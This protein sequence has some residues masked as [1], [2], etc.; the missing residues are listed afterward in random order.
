MDIHGFKEEDITIL[1]DDGSHQNPTYDNILAAFGQLVTQTKAGDC[2][3]LHYSGK[4]R[5]GCFCD[6]CLWHAQLTINLLEICSTGHGGRVKDEDGDEEDGYDET[7]IPVD[8][9]TTGQIT[10]DVIFA[11]LVGRMPQGSTLMTLMDC[12]HSGTVLDLPYTFKADGEQQEMQE[13]PNANMNSLQA[14]AISYLIKKIFGKGV[15]AQIMTVLLVNGVAGITSN[16]GGCGN[17]SGG[18]GGKPSGGSG[19]DMVLPLLQQILKVTG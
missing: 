3:F 11:E 17:P 13:N 10:D 6:A 1:M 12:C 9:S 19:M 16:G 2:A 15:T 4:F 14:M 5:S 7:I 8:F 18:G